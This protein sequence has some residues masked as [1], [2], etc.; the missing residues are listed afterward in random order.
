MILYS[1]REI[2]N[3]RRN[4]TR[5]EWARRQVQAVLE[6]CRP[7]TDRSDDELWKLVTGQGIPRGIHANADLGCPSCGREVY[8]R[9]GN[10][11]WL[12]ALDRPWKLEC[13]SCGQV[14]PKNDFGAFYQ[15]GLGA[16]GLFDAGMADRSLLYNDEHPE[17]DDPPAQ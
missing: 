9:F 12:V 6:A 14:W 3:A 13:P 8:E 7:Y 15:S 1:D 5:F 2:A 11:P 16:N 4:A 10:Y 17:P